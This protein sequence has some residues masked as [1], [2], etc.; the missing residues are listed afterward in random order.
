MRLTHPLGPT[1]LPLPN[2][3]TLREAAA[4]GRLLPPTHPAVRRVARL[5]QQIAAVAADGAGG[6]A[7]SHMR[8]LAWEFA[9]V[10]NAAPNAFVVPGGKVG[11]WRAVLV[12]PG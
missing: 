3:Q 11:W 8:G 5:G 10:D 6:G 7:Y 9:V 1:P 2:P 12:G 4:E